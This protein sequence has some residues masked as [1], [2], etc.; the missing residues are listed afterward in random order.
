MDEHG[1]VTILNGEIWMGEYEIMAC[2]ARRAYRPYTGQGK[3]YKA[4]LLHLY[5]REEHQDSGGALA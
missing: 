2:L 3:I 1:N 4:G 5:G